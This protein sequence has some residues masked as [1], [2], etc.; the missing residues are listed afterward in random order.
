[1]RYSLLL[2]CFT[3]LNAQQG[4][5]NR[6]TLSGGWS[7]QTPA[8]AYEAAQT[9]ATLGISYGFRPWKHVEF[10]A[11][12]FAGLQP[13]PSVCNAH[14]CFD[15]DD[16]LIWVPFGIRFVAPLAAGRIELSAG[17]GG[18]Y[19]A[20]SLTNEA[21]NPFA[22]RSYSGWGGYFT[23]GAAVALDRSRHW[24]LSATPR[25]FLANPQYR[26]DRWFQIAGE[27]SFRF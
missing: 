14:G 4:S 27:V 9:A 25:W 16:R 6:L 5:V 17:G 23:G 20:Y 15:P 19:E 10:E 7:R 3:G 2:L 12:V 26:R 21:S 8:P 22:L 18:L 13:V 11:G 1:M 24:W